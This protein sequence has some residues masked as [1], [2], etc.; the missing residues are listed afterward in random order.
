MSGQAEVTYASPSLRILEMT[1]PVGIRLI[2][3]LDLSD[4][5]GLGRVLKRTLSVR[6]DLYIDLSKLD[7]A[8]VGGMSFAGSEAQAD[9]VQSRHRGYTA[10]VADPAVPLDGAATTTAGRPGSA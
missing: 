4:R 1:A 9:R 3:H 10:A 7:Y 2:G 5:D 8:D 6:R